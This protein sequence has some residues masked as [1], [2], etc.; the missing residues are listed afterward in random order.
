MAYLAYYINFILGK[1]KQN[2]CSLKLYLSSFKQAHVYLHET[3][4]I[5]INALVEIHMKIS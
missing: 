4:S 2:P 1:F 5:F 3:D